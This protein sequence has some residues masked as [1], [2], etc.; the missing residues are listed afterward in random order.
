M[1]FTN[2]LRQH[3]GKLVVAAAILG[4]AITGC[5][6]RTMTSI[7]FGVNTDPVAMNIKDNFA[8]R[9]TDAQTKLI[10]DAANVFTAS[11][12][13]KQKEQLFYS[14]KDNAQRSNWSNFPEGMIP[15]GGLKLGKLTATQR[16]LMDDLLATVLSEQGIENINYQLH[17]EDT[18]EP[19]AMLKYGTEFFY[20]S[21]LGQP[22]ETQPWML[23]FG[24]HH[25]A[26]NVTIYG[27]DAS[28]SPMLTGGQP[29]HINYQNQEI[30]IT[31]SETQAAKNLLDS[32]NNAQ[33]TIAVRSDKAIDLLLGPGEFGTVVV[34]EGIKGSELTQSQKLL[35]IKLINTRLG[36]INKDDYQST[37]ADIINELDD[38]YFGWWG[39]QRELGRAYF[40]VTGPSIIMEYSP[41]DDEGD[42]RT[43]HA[44]SMYRNPQND[45]G[46]A[47]VGNNNE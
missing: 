47:W 10:V 41:Q 2:K 7:M 4:I 18:F 22:S 9:A 23:Q 37:M 14:F 24:G 45:Y 5:S 28:F 26:I 39:E 43:E 40:R 38:T 12:E 15:R 30:F 25:L 35:L 31:R 33:K 13:P 42:I 16:Q 46:N 44:H 36:F 32:L 21:F 3:G 34:A 1:K 19:S 17:A 29:L 8:P 11:L 6:P 20:I 27:K